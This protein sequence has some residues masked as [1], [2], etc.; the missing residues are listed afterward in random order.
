MPTLRGLLA[1]LL[2][3]SV[4]V[5]MTPSASFATPSTTKT[6]E[7]KCGKKRGYCKPAGSESAAIQA[8]AGTI[9]NDRLLIETDST[10]SFAIGASP[11]ST[12][13]ATPNSW[14]L[15]YRWPDASSTSYT[16]IRIDGADY[17][18]GV[19]GNQ[20]EAPTKIN[21]RTNRSSWQIGDIEVTQT[22]QIGSN[23][24]TG[25]KDA[26][27]IAYTLR[28]TGGSPR[29]VGTR[30]MIDTEI[31]QS[32]GFPFRVPGSGIISNETEFTGTLVPDTVLAAATPTTDK[33]VTASVLKSGGATAP[34]RLVL[35]SWSNLSLNSYDYTVDPAVSLTDDSAYALYW[36]PKPLG[37][38][39]SRTF[40]TLYGIGQATVN[41][42][43]PL[44]LSVRGPAAL[45]RTWNDYTP[46]P[47]DITATIS[48]T[49][50]S[51][52]AGTQLSLNLPAGLQLV[53]GSATQ[54]IGNLAAGKEQQVSWRVR[55]PLQHTRATLSYS[56]AASATG[57]AA[58]T[59]SRSITLADLDATQDGPFA[60]T[61]AEYRYDPRLHK[62]VI[63][64]CKQSAFGTAPPASCSDADK[65]PVD[66]WARVYWPKDL[67]KGPYPLL[68]FLHGNHGTC[69]Q[70][71]SGVRKD[72]SSEYTLFGTCT[73]PYD[74]VTPNHEGYAYLGR[75]LA[76]W[77]YIVVSI[78]A[79]RTLTGGNNR[80]SP[81]DS[82]GLDY[83]FMRARGRLVLK[84]LQLWHQWN[85]SG[86]ADASFGSLRA[87]TF[88]G[89]AFR[90]KVDLGNVGLMGHSR[91]G[92]GVRAAYAQYGAS[93]SP[94]PAKVPQLGIKGIFELAPTDFNAN[95]HPMLPPPFEASGT[96]WAV[97]LPM[98]DGDVS[99]LQGV[100]TFDRM[101]PNT[102]EN[103]ATQKIVYTVWGANH[104]F[105]NTEW[106]ESDST[107]CVGSGHTP[108]FTTATI[109]SPEQRQ[110]GLA[111]M[112][113]FFRANVGIDPDAAY[114]L[115]F[116]PLATLPPVVSTLTRVDRSYSVTPN[117]SVSFVLENFRNSAGTNSAGVANDSN[118]ITIS[119]DKIAPIDYDRNG[120]GIVDQQ[121]KHH[122]ASQ[123]V[124]V[125]SWSSAS[126]MT[127]FQTNWR[128]AGNGRDI[129][130]HVSLDFRVARQISALN[131]ASPTNFSIRIVHADGTL[132]GPVSLSAYTSLTGP[133][134]L[135]LS[136]SFNLL[137]PL[138]QTARIPL[139]DFPSAKLD[140]VR[141]VRFTFDSTASG[142]IYVANMVFSRQF[143]PTAF[144]RQF[145]AD[146][147][148]PF[149]L[150]PEQAAQPAPQPDVEIELS[151]PN[152]F[153]IRDALPVLRIGDRDFIFSRSKDSSNKTLIFGL[154]AAEFAAVPDGAPVSLLYG[155]YPGSQEWLFGR[156][157]KSQRRFP[158]QLLATQQAARD[159][160]A[161]LRPQ[162]ASAQEQQQIDVALQR[163]D[164][165]LARG[166]WRDQRHLEPS[167]AD[168]LFDDAQQAVASLQ[169]L[170]RSN[171]AI[172]SAVLRSFIQTRLMHVLRGLAA[173]SI[174]E[175]AAGQPGLDRARDALNRGDAAV[176]NEQFV[177]AVQ[178][179]RNAW[180]QAQPITP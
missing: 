31:N 116:N 22:L 107:G 141:G 102:G 147:A 41:P 119:H 68:V 17:V 45:G 105:Y 27:I 48:N 92:Q 59:V 142:A 87:G 54:T 86:A 5:S 69:G 112:M 131:S 79:N 4:I 114:S 95:L 2:I 174:D 135:P 14:N 78:N 82:A 55:A 133:V 109:G 3:L 70:L 66:L 64:I 130:D 58:K 80:Y 60:V 124:G 84:H 40:V 99:D 85:S 101:L 117:A 168:Q 103:P 75:K 123:R 21:A 98:C 6:P 108:I 19:S 23:S 49:G 178:H 155:P 110:T 100:N 29:S 158:E 61:D 74:I 169:G 161:T 127:F 162:A 172:P 34:D 76:S 33:Y 30:V 121:F 50:T 8:A 94:W 128:T 46:N 134:G 56:V 120:D 104:N 38:G 88:S 146:G 18:Y 166:L 93:G 179:Y 71:V 97:L 138:L 90:G 7:S 156:L 154:S 157:N 77:G 163:L 144:P 13:N 91:G 72:Y 1:P 137:H 20:R 143:E 150:E 151:S 62:D 126:G 43:A 10:G 26:A 44:A 89:S 63:D 57:V 132:S 153:P 164:R 159:L 12:G 51:S 83:G 136:S 15:S 139:K 36:N 152:G 37:S 16:T 28:N 115:N 81:T 111:S 125:I 32:D 129:S 106:Q 140:Q 9:F 24:Q 25:Q 177:S 52:T 118:N 96:A 170:L 11:D 42:A 149:S 73:A 67:S 47:F 65:A 167:S 35:A 113:A 176:F 148:T 175:V 173:Q 145:V 180:R 53:S 171:S 122:D 39:E 160:L 165:T